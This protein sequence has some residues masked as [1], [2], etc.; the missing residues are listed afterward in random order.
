ML[1]FRLPSPVCIYRTYRIRSHI[2]HAG[3]DP[4]VTDC[5]KR[6][7]LDARVSRQ[8][9]EVAL[10]NACPPVLLRLFVR[11]LSTVGQMIVL[12]FTS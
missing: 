1:Q 12:V 11:L 2:H 4:S 10:G 7:V 3:G 5:W 8:G 6:G 9:F